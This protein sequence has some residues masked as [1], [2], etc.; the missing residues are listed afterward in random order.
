M[1]STACST[2][3][4]APRSPNSNSLLAA[5]LPSQATFGSRRACRLDS[6]RR[7][8]DACPNLR[9]W[10]LSCLSSLSSRTLLD[11]RWA[12]TLIRLRRKGSYSILSMDANSVGWLIQTL[13]T[14]ASGNAWICAFCS[15][16]AISAEIDSMIGKFGTDDVSVLSD[17]SSIL[18]R[19]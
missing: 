13:V 14:I 2:L 4:F 12:R 9:S 16:L 5:G 15:R 7:G 6:C 10:A 1:S 3:A 18:R 8:T 19:N 17:I 11:R